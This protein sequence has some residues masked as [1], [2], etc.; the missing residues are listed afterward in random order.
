VSWQDLEIPQDGLM[1]DIVDVQVHD[2][3]QACRTTS[4]HLPEAGDAGRAT[5]R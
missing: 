5:S 4:H 2:F 3:V 1:L